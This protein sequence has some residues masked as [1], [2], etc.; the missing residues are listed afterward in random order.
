LKTAVPA[1]EKIRDQHQSESFRNSAAQYLRF[2][3]SEVASGN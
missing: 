2:F 3:A 1:L